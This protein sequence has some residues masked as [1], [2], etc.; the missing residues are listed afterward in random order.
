MS[1]FLEEDGKRSSSE[2]RAAG[3]LGL[4]NSDAL[5][6]VPR[7]VHVAAPTHGDMVGQE[8]QRNRRQRCSP[9][10]R[11]N[12]PSERAPDQPCASPT[13]RIKIGARTKPDPSRFVYL[14]LR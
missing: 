6:K 2:S 8:L 9:S 10:R 14:V 1:A 7:P 5:G 12:L 11:Q 3:G 13:A 4:F